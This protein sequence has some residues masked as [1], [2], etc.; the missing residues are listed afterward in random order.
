[1]QRTC[2]YN[3]EILELL[4]IDCLHHVVKAGSREHV[5]I[6]LYASHSFLEFEH[7]SIDE[8]IER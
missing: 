2:K 6:S 3:Q 4:D 7:L 5:L 1:M 8:P